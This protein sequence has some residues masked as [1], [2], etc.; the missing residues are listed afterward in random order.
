MKQV[1]AAH[2]HMIWSVATSTDW[3]HTFL[4]QFNMFPCQAQGCQEEQCS[5]CPQRAYSLARKKKNRLVNK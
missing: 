3:V 4:L 5:P 1:I 2:P